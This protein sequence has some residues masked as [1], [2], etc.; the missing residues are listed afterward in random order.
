MNKQPFDSATPRPDRVRTNA[1]VIDIAALMRSIYVH[2]L[3][4]QIARGIIE[5]AKPADAGSPDRRP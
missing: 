3:T 5:R 1:G 2:R 4:E